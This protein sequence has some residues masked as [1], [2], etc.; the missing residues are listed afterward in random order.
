ML[1]LQ[2]GIK[3]ILSSFGSNWVS[4]LFEPFENLCMS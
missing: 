3:L 2:M 4:I 1:S